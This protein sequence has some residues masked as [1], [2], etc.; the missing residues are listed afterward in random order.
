MYLKKKDPDITHW[1]ALDADDLI[2]DNFISCLSEYG[3]SDA[4]ILEN[5][6]FYFKTTGIINEENEFS[7]YCGSSSVISDKYF[8]LP[9]VIEPRSFKSIPFGGISHVHM[10]QKMLERGAS[11][12]VP[13][14]RIIMYVRDNGE[15]ISNDAY[16][17]TFY[18]KFKKFIKMLIRFRFFKK[19]MKAHF[20]V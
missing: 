14:E 8:E 12:V 7:A 10:R 5:G 20:G 11:V 17:N 16:C 18:K 2:H 13:E 15:N 4:I 3:D 9:E 6:Y 1:F 19:D